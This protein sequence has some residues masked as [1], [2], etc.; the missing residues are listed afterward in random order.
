[1]EADVLNMQNYDESDLIDR[2]NVICTINKILTGETKLL[3]IEGDE[4]IGKSTLLREYNKKY[5]SNTI[6]IE[7]DIS[8]RWGSDI[9]FFTY[10]LYTK[11]YGF[12]NGVECNL[13]NIEIPDGELLEILV[14]ANKTL[15][16]RRE[17]LTILIDGLDEISINDSQTIINHLP[18]SNYFS[19][20]K[21]IVTGESGKLSKYFKC[22]FTK[23]YI[24]SG[25]TLSESKEYLSKFISEQ[26]IISEIA[27]TSNG[28]PGYLSSIK[29]MINSGLSPQ[30]VVMQL[31]DNLPKA[32]LNE[33][34]HANITDV[35]LLKVL[36]L[37][38]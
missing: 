38:A 28:N 7:L 25:F 22:N 23:T 32:L 34:N 6:H 9:R 26:D 27:K 33:W 17:S 36:C 4:G 18:I 12:I 30:A 13:D 5:S 24:L 16:K 20:Y 1:M 8:C 37:V 21:L 10:L 3:F 14:L 15:I 2:D 11:L 19:L 31:P 35:N 29:R